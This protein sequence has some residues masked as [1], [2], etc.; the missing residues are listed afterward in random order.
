VNIRPR[1]SAMFSGPLLSF[2]MR[3]HPASGIT[4]YT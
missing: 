2:V 1:M 4:R 3:N